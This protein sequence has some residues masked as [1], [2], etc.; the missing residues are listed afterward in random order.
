MT[1]VD[2]IFVDTS[3]WVALA[4]SDDAHHKRAAAAYPGL[5]SAHRRLITTNLI[6]A[7]TYILLLKE[8]GRQAALAFIDKVKTSP[9]IELVYSNEAI[10]GDAEAILKKY[11]DQDFSYADA[12]SFVVMKQHKVKKVFAFDNHFFSAG[13]IVLPC[14]PR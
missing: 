9:R 3:A 10:E 12:V 6:I 14:E 1:I 2:N 13:F 8:L 5:F 11:Q 4:N 7:E